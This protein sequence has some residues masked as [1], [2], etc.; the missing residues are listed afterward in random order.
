MDK[1]DIVAKNYSSDYENFAKEIYKAG[2]KRGYDKGK[3]ERINKRGKWIVGADGNCYCSEC[4]VSEVEYVYFSV[5][6][7]L[8]N[9]IGGGDSPFCPTCGAE[10]ER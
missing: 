6:G 1:F 7:Q 5:K 4:G 10:M 2:L 8:L 3:N 9:Y